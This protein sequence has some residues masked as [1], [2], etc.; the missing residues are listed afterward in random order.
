[1]VDPSAVLDRNHRH[2]ANSRLFVKI[3]PA[4][5][6]KILGPAVYSGGS[7]ERALRFP[8]RRSVSEKEN[9]IYV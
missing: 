5:K 9:Q 3:A 6:Q 4:I 8:N 1:M 7:R 2:A